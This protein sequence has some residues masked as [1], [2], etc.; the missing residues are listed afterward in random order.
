[1]ASTVLRPASLDW[2]GPRGPLA[3]RGPRNPYVRG[4]VFGSCARE[5]DSHAPAQCRS[6]TL[7]MLTN[8]LRELVGLFVDDGAL[9][10]AILGIP[11]FSRS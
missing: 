7:T 6:F 5:C 1:M 9:A 2:G 4:V 11:R 8:L 10:L 3:G